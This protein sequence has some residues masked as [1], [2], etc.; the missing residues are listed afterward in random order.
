[1]A[2]VLNILL[3]PDGMS[4][5]FDLA[6]VRGNGEKK[7]KP[8]S[9][10]LTLNLTIFRSICFT[11]LFNFREAEI[12]GGPMFKILFRFFTHLTKDIVCW[13]RGFKNISTFTI[14]EQKIWRFR[15]LWLC[16]HNPPGYAGNCNR[17]IMWMCNE[18]IRTSFFFFKLFILNSGRLS[19]VPLI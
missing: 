5:F 15:H 17:R 19:C 12:P 14:L 18:I 1:M 8:K 6:I 11:L 3:T 7:A 10:A 16:L 13:W 9:Q 2:N 4:F